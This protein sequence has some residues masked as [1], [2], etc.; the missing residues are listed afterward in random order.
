[1]NFI[2][3]TKKMFGSKMFLYFLLGLSIFNILGYL[4]I[5][6]IDIIALFSIVA[7][8]VK[9]FTNNM[10]VILLTSLL[11]TNFYMFLFGHMRLSRYL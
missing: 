1:M 10:V 4:Q 9:G 8:L 5:Q 2:D 6:R 11:F 3:T 7:L